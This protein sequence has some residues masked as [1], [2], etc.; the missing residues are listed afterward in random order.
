MLPLNDVKRERHGPGPGVRVARRGGGLKTVVGRDTDPGPASESRGAAA[1][2]RPAA[3]GGPPG[4]GS[5]KRASESAGPSVIA[6]TVRRT[7]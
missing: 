3:L 1:A 6:E 5:V 7:G 4:P 2:S